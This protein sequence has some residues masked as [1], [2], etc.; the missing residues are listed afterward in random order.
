MLK[1]PSGITRGVLQIPA[2]AAVLLGLLAGSTGLQAEELQGAIQ[3]KGSDTMVNLVQAWAEAFMERHPKVMIAVT[4]GGSGTGI[5]ALISG[6]ADLA[7]SSRAIT[8]KELALA[9][10]RG[11][12]PHE[13]TVA[14]DGLAVVV[15]P[16]NPVTQLTLAQ[17]AA[18]FTGVLRNWKELGGADARVVLLS[19]EVNSGTHVYFKGHVLAALPGE[20][21]KEFAPEALLLPSSQAI[22]DEVATNPS[23]IGYYGMGYVHAKNAVV[24]IA[25]TPDGSAVS[26][27]E[28][29]VRSGVYPISRPLL[30][31][32][33]SAPTSVTQAFLDFILSPEGQRIV[34]E[35]DFVPVAPTAS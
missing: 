34:R 18:L 26:P 8:P 1:H 35:I 11:A 6:T 17:V 29:T 4:G 7:A 22:A 31:Y 25:K 32:A 27:T 3:V 16:S 30:L 33:R 13:W 21:P 9:R 10:Q 12:A 20:G 2:Y 23:G 19:R 24:A 5:A 28:E 14:L 15:H